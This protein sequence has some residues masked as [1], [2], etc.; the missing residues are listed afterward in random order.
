MWV[1]RKQ[2]PPIAFFDEEELWNC[3]RHV[4]TTVRK[5]MGQIKLSR[6]QLR[7][8]IPHHIKLPPL[9]D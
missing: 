7:S 1:A 3:V 6:T 8:F 4:E 2:A 9:E 5:L